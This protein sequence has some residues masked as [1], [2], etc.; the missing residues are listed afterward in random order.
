[1]VCISLV[2]CNDIGMCVHPLWNE[3]VHV[4]RCT[5]DLRSAARRVATD[6]SVLVAIGGKR[7]R[8][9][10]GSPA[11]TSRLGVKIERIISDRPTDRRLTEGK[12]GFGRIV[13]GYGYGY[14]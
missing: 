14:G 11:T 7:R 8:G 9:G 2:Y 1:M 5:I 3:G 12:N 6:S 10:T 4:C 13:A